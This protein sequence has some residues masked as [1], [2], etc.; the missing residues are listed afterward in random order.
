MDSGASCNLISK[1]YI[2]LLSNDMHRLVI[3]QS[4]AKRISC[5][6]NTEMECFGETVLQFQIAG[7]VSNIRFL[8]VSGL[9]EDLT[10]IGIGTL[11]YL[12]INIC[13]AQDCIFWQNIAIPFDNVVSTP[14]TVVTKLN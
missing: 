5:A 4:K 11:K 2:D 14:T 13:P 9:S 12:K 7:K 6:N 10:I 1:Q 3:D 8:V